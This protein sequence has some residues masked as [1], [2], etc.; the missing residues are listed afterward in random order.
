MGRNDCHRLSHPF[1]C[2]AAGMCELSESECNAVKAVRKSGRARQWFW[3]WKFE[4]VTH[5]SEQ[6]DHHAVNFTT[7]LNLNT[8]QCDVKSI[9]TSIAHRTGPVHGRSTATTRDPS[10]DEASSSMNTT[11]IPML[12]IEPQSPIHR[13]MVNT[14]HVPRGG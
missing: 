1:L 10:L 12:G 2:P 11:L 14:S 5:C 13:K 4:Y 8:S 3:L 9:P 7:H 6:C